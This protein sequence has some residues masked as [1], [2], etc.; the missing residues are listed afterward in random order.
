MS[1]IGN[2]KN[3]KRNL[4]MLVLASFVLALAASVPANAEDDDQDC[5]HAIE[6]TWILKIHRV[7]SGINFTALQSFTAGG[8]TLATGTIDRMP[9]PPISPLYGSW[10]CTGH[11]SYAV[12][13]NFFAFDPAGTAVAMIKNPET[14]QVVDNDKLTGSSGVA[15]A[16]DINGDNCVAAGDTITFTG[17]RVEP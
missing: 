12:T 16:C 2:R 10:K 9:P 1:I 3:V 17:E 14:I 15:L 5:R 11:K 8:V 13:I 4:S 7:T 6:G